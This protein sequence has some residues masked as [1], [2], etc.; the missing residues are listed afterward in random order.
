MQAAHFLFLSRQWDNDEQY[1]KDHLAYFTE[2]DYPLQL[3]LFPEGTD[4]SP[5]N[6]VKSQKYAEQHNLPKFEYLLQPRTKG[7]ALCVK[8]LLKSPTP[9]TLVNLSV[10]YVGPMPQNERDIIGGN[11]PNEIHFLAER[12]PLAS[13]P[14]DPQ[15][16][17]AWLLEC[18]TKKESQLEHFYEN[19]TFSAPYMS[20]FKM[21]KSDGEM[22]SVMAFWIVFLTYVF[23]SL[24]TSSFYWWYY[25][26]WLTFYLLLNVL[27]S[28][29]DDIIVR[30]HIHSRRN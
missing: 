18:W 7:F 3:L 22:R 28:G 4:L 2:T 26:V 10:G 30:H 16:L 15:E 23:Y 9:V 12:A 5:S 13:L 24:C 8:E 20:A 6:K 17:E 25:P 21:S 19:K 11:W 14:T 29:T 1:I 27:S